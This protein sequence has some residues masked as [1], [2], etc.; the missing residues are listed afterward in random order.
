MLYFPKT[1]STLYASVDGHAVGTIFGHFQLWV[2]TRSRS[3]EHAPDARCV[4]DHIA[5]MQ[6]TY[7]SIIAFTSLHQAL[8]YIPSRSVLQ[9]FPKV[10]QLIT[11][12]QL[13]LAMDSTIKL[14]PE[15]PPVQKVF[16]QMSV[17]QSLIVVFL[18]HLSLHLFYVVVFPPWF[19]CDSL[20]LHSGL[21]SVVSG[22]FLFLQDCLTLH[23]QTDLISVLWYLSQSP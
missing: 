19:Q 8:N 21:S 13:W 14:L 5:F 3:F 11:V 9:C 6:T 2:E 20:L 4:V 23:W 16:H 17:L 1:F 15:D 22:W 12:G 7:S 10:R 18:T